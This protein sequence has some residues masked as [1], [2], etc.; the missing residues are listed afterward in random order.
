MMTKILAIFAIACATL[1]ATTSAVAASSG[2]E[3]TAN[4][5]M[6][7][8]VVHLGAQYDKPSSYS[9]IGGFLFIQTGKEKQKTPI[10]NQVLSFGGQMKVHLT[11][12]NKA[13]VYIAPGFGIHMVK[14]VQDDDFATTTKKSDVT[15]VGPITRIGVLFPINNSTKI[16]IERFEIVNWFDDKFYAASSFAYYSA[17]M[18]FSF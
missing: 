8:S 13:D 6:T 18:S 9:D 4:L 1:M 15:A 2:G 10:I 3:F 12:G 14:D 5:G 7:K 11:S 16:G 17:A